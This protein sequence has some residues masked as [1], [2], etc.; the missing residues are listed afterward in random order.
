MSPSKSMVIQS[1]GKKNKYFI[2]GMKFRLQTGV[3]KK[4]KV[5][6][7]QQFLVYTP[8]SPKFTWG[9]SEF[10]KSDTSARF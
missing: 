2:Q 6:I 10:R 1:R 8:K 7:L 4:N 3:K 5:I 9:Q